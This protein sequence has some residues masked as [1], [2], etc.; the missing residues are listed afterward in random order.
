M[1]KFLKRKKKRQRSRFLSPII[2]KHRETTTSTVDIIK[3]YTV[4]ERERAMMVMRLLEGQG[5]FYN[6]G[7]QW[8]M[9]GLLLQ[10]TCFVFVFVN[11]FSTVPMT[12]GS[13]QGYGNSQA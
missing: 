4:R 7:N 8:K 9:T 10:E 5:P 12:G 3:V 6:Y 11:P 13:E 1:V 2:L